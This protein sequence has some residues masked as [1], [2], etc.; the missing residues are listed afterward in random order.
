[1]FQFMTDIVGPQS[2]VREI[3]NSGNDALLRSA[4]QCVENI[5]LRYDNTIFGFKYRLIIQIILFSCHV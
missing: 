2:V 1:M 3:V 5:C 4:I